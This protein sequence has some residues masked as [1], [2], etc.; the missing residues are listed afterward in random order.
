M[1]TG[2]NSNSNHH[3]LPPRDDRE[4]LSA[5][6]D[7]ELP[8]DA[9]RFALKRLDHDSDW[10]DTCGRWQL[11]GDALRGE[12]TSIAPAG[13]AT[14]VMRT[15]A[16]EAQQAK[17]A[18]PAS[19]QTFESVAASSSRR[20]W[21]GGAALAASVA[22]AAVLVVRPFSESSTSS[23]SQ[24]AAGVVMPATSPAQKT[25]SAPAA[26][27]PSASA[28]A[29][30]DPGSTAN[31]RPSRASRAAVR[32]GR[33]SLIPVPSQTNEPAAVAAAV[34]AATGQPFHP[35]ADEV[36]TRPWP[37]AV[38]SDSTAAGAL[39]VGFGMNSAPPSLYPFEPRLPSDAQQA[40]KPTATDEPQR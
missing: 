31:R 17:V 27:A 32:P 24:V 8:G 11:I 38:L 25:T 35:P 2:S 18:A 19:A 7:G 21:I 3:P 23:G 26:P 33:G 37:R 36:V 16:E 4:T 29:T 13:F 6:F 39:T 10:R 5:L 14:G 12:A 20:R 34:P 28:V 1:T 30:A 15:L 22:M 9:M 40:P